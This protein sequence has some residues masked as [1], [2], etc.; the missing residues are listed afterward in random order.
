MDRDFLKLRAQEKYHDLKIEL[1]TDQEKNFPLS[2]ESVELMP[3]LLRKNF[4]Q[5]V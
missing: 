4:A 2:L 1:E 5:Q 3:Y